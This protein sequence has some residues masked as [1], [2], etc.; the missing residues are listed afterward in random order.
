MLEGFYRYNSAMPDEVDRVRGQTLQE[1]LELLRSLYGFRNL[2][3]GDSAERVKE[4]AIE[5]VRRE[6]RRI[7]L[8]IYDEAAE[9]AFQRVYYQCTDDDLAT[10]DNLFGREKLPYF[11]TP[12]MIKNEALAQTSRYWEGLAD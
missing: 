12:E 7:D 5:Q 3:Y 1:D 4:E 6:F 11:A 10:I 9:D 2:R 8:D